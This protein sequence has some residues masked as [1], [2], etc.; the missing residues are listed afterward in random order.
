MKIKFQFL[1]GS[2]AIILLAGII[3]WRPFNRAR[4]R[5]R[6]RVGK[7]S[8]SAFG[9]E[10]DLAD[11]VKWWFMRDV[12]PNT[13]AIPAD[14]RQRELAYA[15]TLPVHEDYLSGN[16]PNM[17]P[18][19]TGGQYWTAKGPANVGGRTRAL[20]LDVTNENIVLAG[21]VSGG[22]WRSTNGGV[23]WVKTF[24]PSQLQTV[25]CLAQDTRPGKTN[26]WYCGTGEYFGGFVVG[27][28]GIFKSTDS[29]KTWVQ[30]LNINQP[31][32][33]VYTDYIWQII[34][35]PHNAAQDEV[36]MAADGGIY[37]STNGGDSFTL[38]LGA[39]VSG[40]HSSY[41]NIDMTPKGVFYATLSSEGPAGKTGIFRSTNGVKWTNIMPASYEGLYFRTIS[42]IS[43]SNENIV[44]FLSST[45]GTGFKGKSYNGMLDWDCFWKYTYISGGGDSAGGTWEERS[46]NLPT[47]HEDSSWI[48]CDFSTQQGY[49]MVVKVDPNNSN[50]VFLGGSSLYR[51]TDGFT[52]KTN[53]KLIGGYTKATNLYQ[54]QEYK[55][56]HPDQH[57]FI[58]LPSDTNTVYSSC[59]G[60]VFKTT[61]IFADSV[62]WTSLNSSYLTTQF[63]SV[64]LNPTPTLG[65]YVSDIIIGGLQDN[66]TWF[67]GLNNSP[68]SPW[69]QIV[70]GDGGYCAVNDNDTNTTIYGS[71]ELGKIFKYV[72]DK[73]GDSIGWARIDPVGGIGYLFITPF[74]LDP[75]DRNTMYLAAGD[76]I[77]R[78]NNLASIPLSKNNDSTSVGWTELVNSTSN[79]DITSLGISTTP[80]HVL[81][82]GTSGGR[83][84]KMTDAYTGD[85]TPTNV[86][87]S[88]FRFG[89]TVSC[90]A[91]DPEDANK[92]IVVFSNYGIISLY[93][94]SN[95]G[96]NWWNISGNLEEN[97]DGSGNGP[98]CRWAKIIHTT[99]GNSLYLVGTSTGLY[100]TGS[101]NGLKTTW[102]AEA[103]KSIGNTDVEMMDCRIPD[104]IIAVATYG[105]GIYTC[106]IS[107]IT[108]IKPFTGKLPMALTLAQ[109][110]P[111]PASGFTTFTFDLPANEYASLK[112]YDMR[113]HEIMTLAQGNMQT[114]SHTINA[115]LSALKPG[116]YFYQ[117]QAGGQTITKKMLI[118]PE[119]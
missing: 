72:F 100:E 92:A 32:E 105:S 14:M 35:N 111:D 38:V 39:N 3:L 29:G 98:A 46:S 65:S 16:N 50:T 15:S 67:N 87:S 84:Y 7:E 101:L 33:L 57:N 108:G 95:G 58:F 20:A 51:S 63:Y 112:M 17:S 10:E 49:D 54:P 66:Q 69:N 53:T 44:Y 86:S 4:E 2:F 30:K 93:Y 70:R 12:N 21:G 75:N 41:T 8:H 114:G 68:T 40:T 88:A 25:T 107:N 115:N 56:H 78:N 27:G 1:Y 113:G 82:Y 45:M 83:V 90:I 109:N 28:D 23:T 71:V 64:A 119:E 18:M 60:G 81:Y 89:T 76:R 6:E 91:V 118:I 19:L 74:I 26:I 36:W 106:S 62:R 99:T 37:E 104:D 59:D 79:G 102:M 97:P 110:F 31:Q 85:A 48:F 73:N 96:T 24:M 42:G 11:W 116:T 77:W 103:T 117:L 47:F 22:M 61:G 80:A 13:G 5:E 52:S 43:P 94:T 9:E 34:T 55:N